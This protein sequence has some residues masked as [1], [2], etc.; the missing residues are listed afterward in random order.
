MELKLGRRE[1]LK[2]SAALAG[3]VLLPGRGRSEEYALP[4]GTRSLLASSALVYISPLLSDGRESR[5]HG[6]VWFFFDMGDI[7]ISTGRS[8]WKGQAL[9]GGKDRARIWVGD[10]GP[11]RGAKD[12]VA[13][14]PR[15]DAR[16]ELDTDPAT[17][18]RLLDAYARKYPSAWSSWKPRFESGFKNGSR[19]MIRYQPILEV[20]S[21]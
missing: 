3:L 19:L 18:K 6:E 11:Y 13:A 15:F 4:A 2:G 14:A 9:E 5:C 17:F 16:A 1:L 7:V 10:F 21:R 8:T 20:R 12:K